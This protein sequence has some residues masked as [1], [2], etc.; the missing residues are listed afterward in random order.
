[1]GVCTK[2]LHVDLCNV[3][4]HVDLKIVTVCGILNLLRGGED[5]PPKTEAQKKA[6]KKYM[7]NVATIQVRT[8]EQQRDAIKA[9][10]VARKESVNSF[11]N[12]AITNQIERDKGGTA[13][14]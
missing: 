10:A 6:Q 5:L 13:H 12:R 1:M 4:L 2:Y 9:H 3:Y 7:E 8:T 11:I 14:E